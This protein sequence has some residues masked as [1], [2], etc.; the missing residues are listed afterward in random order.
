MAVSLRRD[1]ASSPTECLSGKAKE[2]AD[3]INASGGSAISI[4]GDMLSD[5][6][7]K[8][9]VKKTADFGGGKIHIIVNN[10]GFTWDG[11]LHKVNPTAIRCN[12]DPS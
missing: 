12:T 2:V 3:Q 1:A 8:D 11:V 9:L 6:Y 10:A 7:I 4:P 5:A